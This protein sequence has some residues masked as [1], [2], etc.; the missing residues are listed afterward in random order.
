MAYFVAD[1]KL[2]GY[3]VSGGVTI[4]IVKYHFEC[5][6]AASLPAQTAFISSKSVKISMA[7]TA[8]TLAGNKMYEMNSAGTWVD[9]TDNA[10]EYT[11]PPATENSLGGIMVGEG[12]SVTASGLLSGDF[13]AL[14]DAIYQTEKHLSGIPPLSFMASGNG[15]E[16]F[17]IYGNG[18]QTGTP[19]PE[20]PI[21]PTFC[22]KLDGA[23]WTI[24][25]TCAGQTTPVYLGQTQT[26]RKIRKLVLTGNETYAKDNTGEYLY[27]GYAA[28]LFHTNCLCTHLESTTDY[29]KF[30]KGCSTYNNAAI[31]Y[32]NFGAD[33]MN[34]QSSGNT[35]AGLKEYIAAQYAAGTPVTV[36]YVLANEQTGIVN[37]PLCKIGD[38]ADELHSTDAGVSIPTA[39]GQNT[40]AVGTD[41]QPSEM[42]I[43]YF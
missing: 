12:L 9:V 38:Y 26:V 14:W 8:H 18:Q 35:V 7:S 6:D 4:N 39:R 1:E 37:E 29:P 17:L 13:S 11:L 40:L 41:L 20:A 30:R 16:S 31:V 10:G 23:D 21:M 2:Q 19:T 32:F 33:V 25:I 43:T 5:D 36:W 42:K 3:Y 22:G 28:H 27:Y 34:A 24:P 15:I